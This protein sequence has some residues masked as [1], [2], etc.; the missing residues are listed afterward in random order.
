MVTPPDETAVE[1]YAVIAALRQQLAESLAERDATLARETALA[2]GLDL[3]NRSAGDPQPVFDAILEKAH[4]LCGTASGSLQLYDGQTFL[5]VA[6][7]GRHASFADRPNLFSALIEG[8]SSVQIPDLAELDHTAA[9]KIFEETGSRTLLATAL[10]SSNNKLLGIII[11][12]RTEIHAFSQRE[13][14]LV[15][16]LAA[17]AVIAIEKTDREIALVKNFAA[18]AVIAMD[19]PG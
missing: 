19:N 6:V 17:Q 1:P 5:A 3:I 10:R 16:N 13:T 14:A 4:A 7:H 8:H 9:R 18:Q 15:E 2:E 11:S 12:A